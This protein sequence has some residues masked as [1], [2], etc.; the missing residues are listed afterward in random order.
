M[1]YYYHVY[2]V[3]SNGKKLKHMD[4]VRCISERTAAEQVYMKFGSAS[5]Y[6]GAGRANFV[7]E[8]C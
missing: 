7:A 3:D 4:T 8:K 6:T 1:F 2:L 5:K